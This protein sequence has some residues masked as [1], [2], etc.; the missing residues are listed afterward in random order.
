MPTQILGLSSRDAV[1]RLKHLRI[2]ISSRRA[3]TP[4]TMDHSGWAANKASDPGSCDRMTAAE[5]FRVAHGDALQR[6]RAAER[7]LGAG[8]LVQG[9]L[10]DDRV[11]LHQRVLSGWMPSAG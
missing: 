11:G 6:S 7:D 9:K 4:F 5:R 2:E 8:A 3:D 1:D 10:A